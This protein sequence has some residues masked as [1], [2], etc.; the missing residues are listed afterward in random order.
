MKKIAVY[1]KGNKISLNLQNYLKNIIS[2]NNDVYILKGIN[3]GYNISINAVKDD[4]NIDEIVSNIKSFMIPTEEYSIKEINNLKKILMMTE[5]TKITESEILKDCVKVYEDTTNTKFLNSFQYNLYSLISHKLDLSLKDNYF[6]EN[7]IECL[8][9]LFSDIAHKFHKYVIDEHLRIDGGVS[10][11]SHYVGFI[12]TLDENLRSKIIKDFN[13]RL[14]NMN[15]VKENELNFRYLDIEN[16]KELISI[17]INNN[18]ID[19]Y[20][21]LKREDVLNR[22]QYASENHKKLWTNPLYVSVIEKNIDLI[23][24]RTI[25][26]IMY[27]KILL[28]NFSV[29]DKFFANYAIAKEFNYIK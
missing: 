18:E 8:V 29:I 1:Q 12:N 3:N 27:E 6:K 23:A 11:Y 26:N 20:Y 21:P 28:L 10:H 4:C 14:E 9:K 24:I 15:E 7:K 13:S 22:D 16:I 2:I 25:L 17:A 19:F 5:N